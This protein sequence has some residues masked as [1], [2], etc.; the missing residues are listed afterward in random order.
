[1][2]TTTLKLYSLSYSQAR[3]YMLAAAFVLGNVVVPQLFHLIPRGGLIFLPI[4]FFT[5]VGAYKYGWKVGLLTAVASPLANSALFGMPVI[6][7]LPVLIAKSTLLAFA[8][9]LAAMYFKRLSIAILTLVVLA[10]QLAGTLVEWAIVGDL[11]KAVQDFRL[12]LPGMAL[13]I[14]GGYLAIKYLAGHKE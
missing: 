3:T 11:L 6:A 12:G 10:Y 5:L 8:A 9:G 7:M 4:Y 13:Q 1:M 14:F 2:Q